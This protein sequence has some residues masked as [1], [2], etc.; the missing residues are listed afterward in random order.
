MGLGL[1]ICRDVVVAHGGEIT[2]HAA[3]GG[4]AQFCIALPR[5]LSAAQR[6]A[7]G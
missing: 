3:A 1:A 5:G 2:V 7:A 6:S 4:G